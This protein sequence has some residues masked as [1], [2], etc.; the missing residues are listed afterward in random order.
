MRFLVGLSAGGVISDVLVI[1]IIFLFIFWFLFL[2]LFFPLLR[3][4]N[5]IASSA[6]AD[7]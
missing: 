1:A 5:S 4:R 6:V 7:D 3:F 2:F